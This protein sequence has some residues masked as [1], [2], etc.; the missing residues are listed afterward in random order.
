MKKLL[1]LT[2]GL[3]V[4]ITIGFYSHEVYH[5]RKCEQEIFVKYNALIDIEKVG[6]ESCR[7]LP[8]S[9]YGECIGHVAARLITAEEKVDEELKEEGCYNE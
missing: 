7:A 9:Q 6:A 4:L 8:D 2:A 3:A 1:V 5:K